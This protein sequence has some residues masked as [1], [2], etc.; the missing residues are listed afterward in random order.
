MQKSEESSEEAPE[1]S[2]SE[3]QPHIEQQLLSQAELNDWVRDFGLSKDKSEIFASRMKERGFVFPD[4]KTSVYRN[5]HKQF[6]KYYTKQD[7]ICFCSDIA[8]LFEELNE[9]HSPTEWRLF[10]DSN[11]ESLKAVLLHNGNKKP[12]IPIAHAANSKE[13]YDTMDTLLTCIEHGKHK[14]KICADLT[15]VSILS[16]LK[17]GYPKYCCFL[18]LWDSRAVKEHYIKKNKWEPRTDTV[19]G[20]GSIQRSNL[21]EREDIILPPLHIKLGLIKSFIVR[22]QKRQKNEESHEIFHHLKTIFPHLSTSKIEAG[23]FAGPEVRTLLKDKE[24]PN[25]FAPV[26]AAGWSS[27]K[28]VVE[29]FLGNR[30]REDYKEIVEDLIKNYG[31][32]GKPLKLLRIVCI[33]Y[34]GFNFSFYIICFQE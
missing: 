27:F 32:L 25:L 12:S 5:R 23:V 19:I 21:A 18:C 22:L 6:A 28:L 1:S 34:K 29:N 24:F 13:D 16:G 31:K 30:R 20:E 11:K 10:I 15:V 7:D 33:Y 4:V 17:G 3:F 14:W 9:V 26:E 2:G 8:G